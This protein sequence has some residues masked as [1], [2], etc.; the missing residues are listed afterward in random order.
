MITDFRAFMGVS[1]AAYLAGHLPPTTTPCAELTRA[2]LAR[3]V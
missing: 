3:P 2:D 1:P